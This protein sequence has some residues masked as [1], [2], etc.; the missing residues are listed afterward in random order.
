MK[1][2][3]IGPVYPYRGGIAQ[4]TARLAQVLS[5]HHEVRV[6]SF[7]RLYPAWLYPGRSDKDLSL[8]V[9]DVGATF[10][11]DSL[12]PLSWLC[13]AS[14]IRRYKP[15]VLIIGWWVTFLT[16]AF[17]TIGYLCR[18]SKIPV[19]FLIHNVLPHE[20]SWLHQPLAW[21]T[22][23]QGSHFIVHT[24]QECKRLK[25]LIPDAKVDTIPFP[26]YDMLDGPSPLTQAEARRQLNIPE[27][28]RVVLFFGF[29]RPYKGL[30]YL[31]EALARL[32]DKIQGLY[33]VVA[34]EFWEN[35]EAY[36]QKIE[37]MGL[38]GQVQLE[39]RY[40][41]NE[42]LGVFFR[43]ADL[44]VA[45]YV[46]GTQSAVSALALGFGIPL[47]ATEWS[48]A[49]I[50]KAHKEMVRLVPS[51][52]VNALADAIQ[53]FF[54]SHRPPVSTAPLPDLNGWETLVAT[55]EKIAR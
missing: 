28:G 29:V 50:D 35:M 8:K 2:A 38:S 31:I 39:D 33:L 24:S 54:E 20:K 47:V 5:V 44:A 37:A 14:E 36:L 30:I 27:K 43:A 49:G 12:N 45:P 10:T 16:P 32:N 23:K 11:I 46:G 17:T 1:I 19:A 40:I 22:L 52:D 25:V 13:T 15:D 51:G 42:E 3:L 6:Y 4:Y 9:I 34:G 55:I 26:V 21:M 48:S 7:K 53:T 18:I 41:P